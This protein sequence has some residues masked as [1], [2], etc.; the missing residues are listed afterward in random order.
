MF[1]CVEAGPVVHEER[2]PSEENLFAG[3]RMVDSNQ[4][5]RKQLDPV[6]RLQ[7]ILKFRMFVDDDDDAQGG[8]LASKFA[9]VGEHVAMGEQQLPPEE[10]TNEVAVSEDQNVVLGSNRPKRVIR[11]PVKYVN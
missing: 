11:R 5:P 7:K 9:D 8:E 3:K 2:G 6:A 1:I 4:T 10:V